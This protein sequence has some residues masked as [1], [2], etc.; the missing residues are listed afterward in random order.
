MLS[1]SPSVEPSLLQTP[2]SQVKSVLNSEVSSLEELCMQMCY[3]GADKSVQF[4]G[5]YT[6]NISL[7]IT[8][9]SLVM[10][11]MAI[12]PTERFHWS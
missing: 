9:F 8:R 12:P 7:E 3:L 10:V 5:V 4:R 2:L 6:I 11:V 1:Q